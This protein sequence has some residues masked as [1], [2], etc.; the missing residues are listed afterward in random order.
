MQ[1]NWLNPL[2]GVKRGW[3]EIS[4]VYENIFNGSAKVYVEYFDYTILEG[5]DFFKPWVESEAILKMEIVGL[6]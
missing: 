2:G 1:A 6:N 5:D 3:P 4:G